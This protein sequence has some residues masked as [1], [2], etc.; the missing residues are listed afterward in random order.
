MFTFNWEGCFCRQN[1]LPLPK[2]NDLM[3][4][5][6]PFFSEQYA[7]LSRAKDTDKALKEIDRTYRNLISKTE[8]IAAEIVQNTFVEYS[9]LAVLMTLTI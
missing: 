3:N 5:I 8:E 6:F 2:N 1:I 7:K 9:S 4:F